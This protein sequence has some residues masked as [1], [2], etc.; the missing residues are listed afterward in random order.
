MRHVCGAVIG[1]PDW[2]S[3]DAVAMVAT[4][5]VLSVLGWGSRFPWSVPAI[6][7]GAGGTEV[8]PVMVVAVSGLVATVTPCERAD[9]LT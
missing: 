1:L 8:E 9:Q 3:A 6:L 2:S 7:A 4:C 5:Q